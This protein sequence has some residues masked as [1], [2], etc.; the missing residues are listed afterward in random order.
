[1]ADTDSRSSTGERVALG[2]LAVFTALVGAASL[3]WPFGWDAGIFTW[4]GDAIRRGGLPYRDALDMKGPFAFYM[5]AWLQGLGGTAMWPVRL[6]DLGVM[7]AGAIA[8]ATIVR[9]FAPGT[10]G[11]W[12]ALLC[13]LYHYNT[14]FWNTAQPDGWIAVA[15][16]VALALLLRADAAE[17]WWPA[18]LAALLV[19]LGLV[20]K[21]TYGLLLALPPLAMLLTDGAAPL[22]R[23]GRAAVLGAVS[24]LPFAAT[25]AWF[26]AR[27]ATHWLLEG[28]LTLNLE[29]SEALVGGVVRGLMYTVLRVTEVPVA[30][31]IPAA[32]VGAVLLWRRDRRATLLLLWLVGS[33][34]VGIAVQRRWFTYHWHSLAWAMAPLAGVGLGLSLRAARGG[35][36]RAFAAASLALLAFAFCFPLQMRA[37]EWAELLTGRMGRE[38]YLRS[39]P[40][41]EIGLVMDD[42]A[43][44]AYLRER[45]A[46]DDRVFVWDSPL[47]N[48][49][50]DRRTPGRVGFFWP[51][52]RAGT[53][54]T[55]PGPLQRELRA[56]FRRELD[57]PTTRVVAVTAAALAEH[58]DIPR[59]N[60]GILYREFGELLR[61]EWQVIDTVGSYRI[62]VRRRADGA[63]T[64]HPDPS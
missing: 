63:P 34:V 25:L 16:T 46:P 54:T 28:Y 43:L 45:T 39:F 2:V 40:M 42:L 47:A 29:I 7:L 23:L 6:F 55:A 50:A 27:D 10:A 5:Y 49:L 48:A 17:R 41:S 4:V 1:M 14:D 9:R 57:A 59:R 8:V 60:I 38:A 61:A 33:A 15:A 30:L 58:E 44:G 3:W 11:L 12:S 37:R 20:Q 26:A 22:R 62:F 21:P 31:A 53:M 19:G 35:A 32:A 52:V 36:E 24:L 18:V 56:Q 64:P 13:L 51:L